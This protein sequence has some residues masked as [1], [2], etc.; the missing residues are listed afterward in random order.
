[1]RDVEGPYYFYLRRGDTDPSLND[2]TDGREDSVLKFCVSTIR[3]LY[4]E[5]LSIQLKDW[6]YTV[7]D[8]NLYSG[9]I[10]IPIYFTM[11]S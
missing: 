2:C 8:I 9:N 5:G 4:R 11:Y 6:G 1:M 3:N 10:L 7:T